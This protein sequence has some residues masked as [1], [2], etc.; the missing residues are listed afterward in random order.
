MSFSLQDA[1]R[2]AEIVAYYQPQIDLQTGEIVGVEAL[3][4][5]RHPTLGLLTPESFI[6]DAEEDGTIHEIG[7]FMLDDGCRCAAEWHRDG[8]D[9]EVAVNVSAAQLTS[10]AFFQRVTDNL[11]NLALG[12]HSITVEITESRAIVDPA[13]AAER[14]RVLRRAGVDVSIDDFGTGHSSLA[15]LRDVPFT[16][17]KVDRGFV[18]GARTNAII[19][20]ILEGSVEFASRLGMQSVAEGVETVDDWFLLREIG[21]DIAQGYFIG[22]PAPAESL[23]P[24]LAA[25]QERLERV[26]QLVS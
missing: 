16:E 15:Q 26:E 14:L 17:L 2:R 13:D 3:S 10:D 1:V 12:P 5:W 19:R 8:Y 11:A 7:A 25:W 24:W 23:R 18:K 9:I 21:C 6:A 22:R 4:R 20:P